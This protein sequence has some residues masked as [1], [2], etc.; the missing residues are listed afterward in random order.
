M[1][2]IDAC[3]LPHIISSPVETSVG[4]AAGAHLAAALDPSP[5]AHALGTGVLLAIDVTD[6]RLLP[7]DGWLQVRRVEP[8]PDSL[9]GV[10]EVEV[11]NGEIVAAN[12]AGSSR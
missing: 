8:D 2:I 7:E 12:D 11:R 9:Y 1:R 4:I 10:E 3:G 5:Y 6:D